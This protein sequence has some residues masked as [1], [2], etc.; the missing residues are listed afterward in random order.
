[1]SEDQSKARSLI[2]ELRNRRVFRVAAVYLGIGFV[3]LKTCHMLF[4]ELGVP[5]WIASLILGM[6]AAGFPAALYLS[7]HYEISPNGMDKS[8]HSEHPQTVKQKPLTSNIIIAVLA[9]IILALFAIPKIWEI[10]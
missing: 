9:A 2:Q 8:K 1:M 6:L 4:P 7:W 10:N 5:D 3:I